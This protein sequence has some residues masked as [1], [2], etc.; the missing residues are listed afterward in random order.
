[1]VSNSPGSAALELVG[2][3][4]AGGK[5]AGLVCGPQSLNSAAGLTSPGQSGCE[6]FWKGR[7][8]GWVFQRGRGVENDSP[9]LI[10]LLCELPDVRLCPI[11]VIS[12]NVMQYF[13]T[14]CF[15]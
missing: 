1:M 2:A 15:F 14:E 9:L 3:A 13:T 4:A 8:A 12:K 11:N 6:A 5:A 7:L 10:A